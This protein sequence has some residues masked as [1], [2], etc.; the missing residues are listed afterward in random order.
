MEDEGEIEEDVEE[1]EDIED[2]KGNDAEDYENKIQEGNGEDEE[3]E[4]D[5]E[6]ERKNWR[7]QVQLHYPNLKAVYLEDVE[8][9]DFQSLPHTRQIAFQRA[10][11]LGKQK[12]VDVHTQC[13][14]L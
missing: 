3:E 14:D 6:D 8:T 7:K 4:E 2:Y 12:G 1:S 9:S 13:V 10:I 5:E 11:E